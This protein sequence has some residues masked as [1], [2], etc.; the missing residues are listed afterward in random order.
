MKMSN[1][2]LWLDDDSGE[3]D[4]G[5][6]DVFFGP[7]GIEIINSL[8]E[9]N[10]EEGSTPAERMGIINVA[11]LIEGLIERN[12]QFD[13]N[14]CSTT[15]EFNEKVSTELFVKNK[16]NVVPCMSTVKICEISHQVMN[17]YLNVTHESNFDYYKLFEII[18]S[19][20]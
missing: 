4:P 9:S 17:D 16:K 20:I 10:V 12:K 14:E 3:F 1:N 2:S 6:E 19:K 7:S 13:C 8:S 5:S 18:K 11:G 15:F